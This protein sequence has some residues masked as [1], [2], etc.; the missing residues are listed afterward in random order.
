MGCHFL[1][2]KPD[3]LLLVNFIA[4]GGLVLQLDGKG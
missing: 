2:E 1:F 3:V 4:S